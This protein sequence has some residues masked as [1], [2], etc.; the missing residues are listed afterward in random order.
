MRTAA[1]ARVAR[2]F[3]STRASPSMIWRTGRTSAAGSGLRQLLNQGV[4]FFRR[5]GGGNLDRRGL[6]A[7]PGF[8]ILQRKIDAA[9]FASSGLQGSCGVE[10]NRAS[11]KGEI[12]RLSSAG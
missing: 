1:A 2:V 6:N 4:D 11:L 8:E 3:P 10:V 7:S 5:A 12:E 9:V